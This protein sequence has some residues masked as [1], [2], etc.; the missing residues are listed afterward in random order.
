MK[1]NVMIIFA[2]GSKQM[3]HNLDDTMLRWQER[4][5]KTVDEVFRFSR[6]GIP[7]PDY[8]EP[9]T[10]ADAMKFRGEIQGMIA[11]I[12][13][14]QNLIKN[15]PGYKKQWFHLMNVNQELGRQS[16]VMKEFIK[17][18]NLQNL[19][20]DRDTSKTIKIDNL[21]EENKRLQK[22]L[23]EYRR[24]LALARKEIRQL[25]RVLIDQFHIEGLDLSE[26]EE[27][28][29]PIGDIAS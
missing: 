5:L 1:R 25:Q 29:E 22:E 8:G 3:A 15:N 24:G 20:S 12:N 4:R 23:G 9:Q 19:A 26:F 11:T 16:M 7:I 17:Q 10:I 21:K 28:I 18:F 14:Q 2:D 6:E 13:L 27:S